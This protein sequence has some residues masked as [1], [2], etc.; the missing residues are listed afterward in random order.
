MGQFAP[1]FLEQQLAHRKIKGSV[2]IDEQHGGGQQN[3]GAVSLD[4]QRPVGDQEPALIEQKEPCCHEQNRGRAENVSD[5]GKLLLKCLVL[6]EVGDRQAQRIDW[7]HRVGNDV[8][9]DEDKVR[10]VLL[11]LQFRSVTVVVIHALEVD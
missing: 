11:A 10:R 2:D 8:L 4:Q 9:D 3:C 6:A 5:H 1:G 7:N